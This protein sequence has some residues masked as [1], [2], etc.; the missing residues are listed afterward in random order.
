LK[1]LEHQDR[2]ESQFDKQ[3]ARSTFLYL[4]FFFFSSITKLYSSDFFF[5]DKFQRIPEVTVSTVFTQSSTLA[6]G[7]MGSA[8]E[9]ATFC[10]ERPGHGGWNS[11][12]HGNLFVNVHT[13]VT[14]I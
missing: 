9:A 1:K 13:P 10:T 2:I 4:I 6:L 8:P 5:C 3:I 12:I 11:T 7:S 14:A